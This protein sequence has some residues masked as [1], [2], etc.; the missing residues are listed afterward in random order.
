MY[1][2]LI[3]RF[4]LQ[5]TG[6]H[7][8][9]IRRRVAQ[10]SV[11]AF[12]PS[13]ILGNCNGARTGSRNIITYRSSST[14]L[15]SAANTN[16]NANDQRPKIRLYQYA[17]CP[18][19]HSVKSVLNYARIRVDDY[20]VVEVNPLTKSEIKPWK[21]QHTKVPIAVLK[22]NENHSDEKVLFG[23]DVIVQA[24]LDH[25]WIQKSIQSRWST[26]STDIKDDLPVEETMTWSNFCQSP[27]VTQWRSFASN[28][29]AVLLYPNMC[30]TWNDSY[31]AFQYVHDDKN[32]FSF[33]QRVL[34]QNVGSLVSGSFLSSISFS[35]KSC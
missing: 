13:N 10:C 19:C 26:G 33:F 35:R 25:P 18:F 30:R 9:P 4:F 31:R 27:T 17:I 16:A 34:I 21:K 8:N 23:S 2:Y 12:S 11:A 5:R 28:E 3:M 14:F 32:S 24:L 20:D 29:L 15:E 6:I 22:S 7:P 1:R